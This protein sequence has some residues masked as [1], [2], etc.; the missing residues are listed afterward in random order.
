MKTTINAESHKELSL[1]LKQ[2]NSWQGR[3]G[4]NSKLM[5]KPIWILHN[6]ILRKMK[7]QVLE[8]LN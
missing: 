4:G 6:L 1:S 7:E 3:A 8:T 5:S 2:Y